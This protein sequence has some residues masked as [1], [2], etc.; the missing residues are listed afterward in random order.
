MVWRGRERAGAEVECWAEVAWRA[1]AGGGGRCSSGGGQSQT[2][3]LRG[4]AARPAR[5]PWWKCCLCSKGIKEGR[6]V[7]WAV[8][9]APPGGGPSCPSWGTSLPGGLPVV[10]ARPPTPGTLA[11]A[12]LTCTV[13]GLGTIGSGG[14][15]PGTGGWSGSPSSERGWACQRSGEPVGCRKDRL[16]VLKELWSDGWIEVWWEEEVFQS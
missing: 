10:R 11:Q 7:S 6:C 4:C 9:R 16:N 15:P 8:W 14:T 3:H 12:P 13:S 2:T 1:A 5:I